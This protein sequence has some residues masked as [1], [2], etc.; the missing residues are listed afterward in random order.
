M[1]MS[2]STNPQEMPMLMAVSFLSPVSIHTLIPALLMICIVFLTLSW[3][4]SS[5]AVAPMRSNSFSSISSIYFELLV[6]YS[7]SLSKYFSMNIF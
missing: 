4:W 3:S 6:H 2:G 1:A 7:L 5:M